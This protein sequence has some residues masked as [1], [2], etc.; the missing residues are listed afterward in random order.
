MFALDEAKSSIE[1]MMQ[2]RSRLIEA[3]QQF[4]GMQ[5]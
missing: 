1:F 5:L 3:Y 2:V 4:A